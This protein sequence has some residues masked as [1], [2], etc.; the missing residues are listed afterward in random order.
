LVN[1]TNFINALYYLIVIRNLPYIIIKW[2]EFRAFLHI[3]NYTVNNLLYKSASLVP[4]LI[5]KTF[6]IYK[7]LVK[8]RLKKAILKVHFITNCWTAPNK[9]AFQVVTAYF[10]NEAGH[11]LKATLAL[12]EHKESH[13]GKE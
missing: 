6:I 2:P 5:S 12:W 3:Y 8:K 4:L 11:L 9:S 1:K 7:D 10:I 13:S